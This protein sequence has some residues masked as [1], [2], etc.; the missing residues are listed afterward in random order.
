MAPDKPLPLSASLLADLARRHGTP[1]YVYDAATIRARTSELARL[2][3]RVR[4]AQKANSNPALL[5][6]VRAQ[7]CLVDA[8]S[9]GEVE[10][11][12]AAGHAPHEIVFT[13]D[14]FDRAALECIA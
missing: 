14:L 9:A 8:V 11:A 2:F 5:E 4:Y 13:S 7:G 6:L 1:L 12:L 10:C 3:D